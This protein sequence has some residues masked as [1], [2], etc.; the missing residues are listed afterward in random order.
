MRERAE[1]SRARKD[2]AVA[3]GL[4]WSDDLGDE[5]GMFFPGIK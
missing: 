1:R 3:R 5:N 2:I 4:A